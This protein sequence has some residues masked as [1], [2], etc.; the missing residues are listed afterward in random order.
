MVSEEEEEAYQKSSQGTRKLLISRVVI[1]T[2]MGR[3]NVSISGVSERESV[4][5]S[6][7]P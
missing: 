6:A 2:Y 7:D 1:D 4:S 3:F 5:A